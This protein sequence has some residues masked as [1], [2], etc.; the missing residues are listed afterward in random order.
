[1]HL[2]NLNAVATEGYNNFEWK[3]T[4]NEEN[5]AILLGLEVDEEQAGTLAARDAFDVYLYQPKAAGLAIFSG[6]LIGG[7]A[8]WQGKLPCHAPYILHA[9]FYHCRAGNKIALKMMFARKG[10]V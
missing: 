6:W 3:F 5:P 8:N 10:E 4:E 9:D 7:Q 2:F 1:M